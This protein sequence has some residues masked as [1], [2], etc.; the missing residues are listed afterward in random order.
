MT[1]PLGPSGS[2]H[3]GPVLRAAVA[4]ALGLALAGCG[5]L[6]DM[7]EPLPSSFV[8]TPT[9]AATLV[10]PGNLS[11]D[12]VAAAERMAVRVRNVGCGEL[13]T[14]SGFALDTT[15][16]V[17]NRHVIE[18]A[19]ELQVSTY[20]G[21]EI[22]VVSARA[23]AFADLALIRTSAELPFAPVLADGDPV[24]GDTVTIVGYPLGGRLTVSTGKVLGTTTDPQ[25]VA[26]GAVLV[27]DAPVEQGSSGSAALDA[28]GRV[29]GVVYGRDAAGQSY[30]VPVSTL[31]SLLADESGF[32]ELSPCDVDG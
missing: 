14:G 23:A 27:T 9:P 25:N 8:A 31:A 5:A 21:H 1:R 18:D 12:G 3:A 24:A 11:P 7:P 17:T 13:S 16:A 32:D 10:D 19:A 6:P 30:L 15:T 4:A 20:D 28:Q 26:L 29:V 2:T 22:D